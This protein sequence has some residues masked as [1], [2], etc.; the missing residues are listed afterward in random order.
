MRILDRYAVR[1]LVPV[2]IWCLIVFVFLSCVIDLFEHLDEILRYHIPVATVAR[3]YLS[4]VPLV[5]VRASPLA[6]LL[7][8]AFVASRLCRYQEL[9]AMHASGTS[10]RRAG[11]PFLFVGWLASLAMFVVNDRVVPQS[12]LV[13]ERIRQDAF[14]GNRQD[15]QW[16]NVAIMDAAN[17]LYH[18]RQLDLAAKE[19]SDLTVLE[20]DWSNRPTKN[21]YAS[22][23]IWTPHGW[24]LLYGTIYRIG[25]GGMLR[26]EPQPFVER[27]TRYPVKPESFIQGEARPETMRY[28]QLRRL[29]HRLKEAGLIQTRRYVVELWAKITLPLM[30]VFVCLIGF[31]GS[32]QPQLRGNIRGLGMSLFWGVV[33]YVGVAIGHGVGKAGLLPAVLAV[34]LPHLIAVGCC[35]RELRRMT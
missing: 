28:S 7:A 14:K 1:Q 5:I 9:L 11:V 12:V 17:R 25:P 20:H 13:Y 2:W 21:L 33:Y 3:Y 24:L 34:W 15:R 35:V 6:L 32:T 4:F 8:A 19:L 22:R 26:G 27:L 10:L 29:I 23:A 16:E 18:A 31:A 30:N